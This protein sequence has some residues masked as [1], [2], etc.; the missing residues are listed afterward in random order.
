MSSLSDTSLMPFGRYRGTAMQFV[1]RS[2]LDWLQRQIRQ[3]DSFQAI[4]SDQRAVLS[5]IDG[6]ADP[7]V[8]KLRISRA[9]H[10][11]ACACAAAVDLTLAEFC[12]RCLGKWA[13][14]ELP[15]HVAD[16]ATLLTATAQDSTV[17]SIPGVKCAPHIMR[18]CIASGV[19]FA[20]ARKPV[21]FTPP[22]REGVDYLVE[23][24]DS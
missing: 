6:I 12:R 22:E 23:K 14:G 20:E 7:L 21:P 2:Y 19:E 18:L 16:S 9:L 8:M 1:P 11:R 5:Y 13:R 15:H 10:E 24:E 17:I 3:P 4:N